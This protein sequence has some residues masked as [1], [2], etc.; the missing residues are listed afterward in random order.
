MLFKSPKP[1]SWVAISICIPISAT[2]VA[3]NGSRPAPV[4]P[5]E[6]VTM[7]C[8]NTHDSL[9]VKKTARA[10]QADTVI[11]INVVSPGINSR[12]RQLAISSLNESIRVWRSAILDFG[13]VRLVEFNDPAD[14]KIEFKRSV[15]MSGEPVAGTI[16]WRRDSGTGEKVFIQVAIN[17]PHGEA[18][19][20][21][22]IANIISHEIGHSL[23]LD[24]STRPTGVMRRIDTTSAVVSPSQEEVLMVRQIREDGIKS[25]CASRMHR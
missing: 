25:M 22:T 8:L 5:A 3:I 16:S 23:G 9:E 21:R 20:S 18:F 15:S 2:W 6:P 17:H 10:I 19:A 14:I 4:T 12:E 1:F 13:E 7:R 11:G 24:D